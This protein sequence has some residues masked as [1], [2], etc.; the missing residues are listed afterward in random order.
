MSHK[1]T[2]I[3]QLREK[4]LNSR[5]SLSELGRQAG[6]PLTTLHSLVRGNTKRIGL[7]TAL[8]L[9]KFFGV[10]LDQ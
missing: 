6:V 1:L 5:L 3:E 10:K 8:R 9:G 4:C 7:E 2:I